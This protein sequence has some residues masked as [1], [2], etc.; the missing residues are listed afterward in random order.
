MY[1]DLY[2][3]LSSKFK[4]LLCHTSDTL[5]INFTQKFIFILKNDT[6]CNRFMHDTECS[7]MTKIY[8]FSKKH[9]FI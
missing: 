5:S 2:W 7:S 4:N 8:S 6:A 3:K 1:G 9:L